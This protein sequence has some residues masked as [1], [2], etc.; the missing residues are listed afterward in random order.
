LWIAFRDQLPHTLFGR[1]CDA[2]TEVAAGQCVVDVA[3]GNPVEKRGFPRAIGTGESDAFGADDCQ[4]PA[5]KNGRGIGKAGI[6]ELGVNMSNLP[7]R[8]LRRSITLP[9]LRHDSW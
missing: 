3:A 9:Y 1:Q 5:A 6:G 2:L 7:Q 4:Q 8:T